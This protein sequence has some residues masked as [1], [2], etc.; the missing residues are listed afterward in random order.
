MHQA[1]HLPRKSHRQSGGD[2]T[3]QERTS[4]PLQITDQSPTPA[5][6]KPPAE[7]RRPNDARTYGN[8]SDPGGDHMTPEHTSD[9][10]HGPEPHA[11]DAKATERNLLDVNLCDANLCDVN[12]CGMSICAMSTRVTSICAM[13]TCHVN[14]CDANLL[15]SALALLVC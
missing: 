14:L 10:D 7:R 12:H 2:Q 15:R 8:T 5:T 4:D 9:P 6:Q 3:T 1:P 11:C 13:S